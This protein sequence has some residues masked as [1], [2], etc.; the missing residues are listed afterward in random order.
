MYGIS[1]MYQRLK[2]TV[3]PSTEQ[4]LRRGGLWRSAGGVVAATERAV[5]LVG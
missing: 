2:G 1:T 4:M 5:N 3:P